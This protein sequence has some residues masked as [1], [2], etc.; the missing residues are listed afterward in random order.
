MSF[1]PFYFHVPSLDQIIVPVSLS[2]TPS[3]TVLEAVNLMS[4]MTNSTTRS[5][6]KP[7]ENQQGD[8]GLRHRCILVIEAD[9]W[10]GILGEHHI[11]QAIASG[12][13]LA[14]LSVAEV[15]TTP[16]ISLNLDDDLSNNLQ[17]IL[18]LLQ[19]YQLD[20]LPVLNAQGKI[21]GI[22]TAHSILHHLQPIHSPHPTE[23]EVLSVEEQKPSVE[24]PPENQLKRELAE[25][26]TQLNT[27][28]Q[29]IQQAINQ[30]Q[31][32]QRIDHKL[33]SSQQEIRAFL[34]ALSDVMLII[35]LRENTV[36]I[37]ETPPN[38]F[39]PTHSEII[40]ETI[41]QLSQHSLSEHLIH[42]IRQALKSQEVVSFEYSLNTK[43]G[44]FW[45]SAKISP[46][47][48]NSVIWVAQDI[49]KRKQAEQALQQLTNV[50]ESRVTE[51]T[52]ELQKV[53]TN[54]R[55]VLHERELAE[56][57][58]RDSEQKFRQLAESIRE[59]FFI[60]SLDAFNL[61]Y[62]SPAFEHIWGI[63]PVSLYENPRLWIEMIHPEDQKQIEDTLLAEF[64]RGN[65]DQ[66]FRI[67]RPDGE[68]R[69]I[70]T[71]TFPVENDSEIVYRI[72]GLAEDVT[73]RRRVEK[74]LQ[75]RE[76][77]LATLADIS[78]VGIFHTDIAGYYLYV[79]ER[80]SEIVGQPFREF[81]GQHWMLMVHPSDRPY[82][83]KAW[84][85]TRNH[86]QPLELEYKI[87]RSD[88]IITWVFAQII[89]DFDDW[90]IVKG[91]VGT[92]TNISERKQIETELQQLNQQ[93]ET[94]VEQR[95]AQLQQTNEK[96]R[97]E[98]NQRQQVQ[99]QIA[100]KANQQAI[101]ANLGQKALSGIDYNQLIQQVGVQVSRCLGVE[102][103]QVLNVPIQDPSLLRLLTEIQPNNSQL[104]PSEALNQTRSEDLKIDLVEQA[105]SFSQ[106]DSNSNLYGLSIAIESRTTCFGILSAYT[107]QQRVFNR[108][109]VYFIQSV[110]HI[111]A[112]VIE[113]NETESQLKTSLQQKEV[114]LKEIHHRVKNNLLVVSNILEF[115]TD[116]TENP[117]VIKI[118][119]ESQRR[120]ESMA[121]IHEKLY[122][123]TGLDKIDFGDYIQDLVSQLR[124]SYDFNSQLIEL[125]LDVEGIALNLETAHPC[126]L[127][128]NELVSNAFQHAFP[129][130]RSGK[131]W[132]KFH[133][134]SDGIVTL[135]V[136]D[137][138][139]G[140][141]QNIDFRQIDSLG[142]E[143][144]CTLINQLEGEIEL[145]RDQG[146]TFSLT[147]KELQYRQRY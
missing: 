74:A 136:R 32:I 75:E 145:I 72:V 6:D 128:V 113:R 94:I 18:S 77:Q 146:T 12:K 62:V 37:Q 88:Q 58:L 87:N 106:V 29:R 57:Q 30:R 41:Q 4:Q 36:E 27:A 46:L 85:M 68:I 43:E 14:S 138:G 35:Y 59:V 81:M 93:L 107:R 22:I 117:E 52:N 142:M 124:E 80:T 69:W 20:Q 2:L 24:N 140:F 19:H 105:I 118:L 123:S 110:A 26:K 31:L 33:R 25:Y 55:Q 135:T 119:Q 112:T 144:V 76:G 79:N 39:Y 28:N 104:N 70:L 101:I 108:D 100:A 21:Q 42:P 134:N 50:L 51:R 66:E 49:T 83:E 1:N 56:Q 5:S 139:I 86:D 97:H 64:S 45:F 78:P 82:V 143:L 23:T 127:I 15:M 40:A 92:L 137:N 61:L 9:Q 38:P 8:S 96:L 95:T 16:N 47:V 11:I 3:Q 133:Q 99:D 34:A 121:L 98:I 129:D 90:G 89:P 115:Q 60:W 102:S 71:R 65:F 10:M 17:T 111:L 114:L 109:D 48:D 141:P 13:N 54:L 44:M 7:G 130:H 131:I 67:I 147:F 132:V 126:G 91:F 73:E 122:E 116:Y 84:F 120:I 103:V 125:E 53:N 63:S